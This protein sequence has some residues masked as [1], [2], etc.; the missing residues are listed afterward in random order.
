MDLNSL[1]IGGYQEGDIAEIMT[2]ERDCFSTPWSENIFRSELVSPLSR[3]L[4]GRTDHGQGKCVVGY[5]VY[6]RV[7]DEIHLHNI[8][9]RR[10]LQ[11]QGIASRLLNEVMRRSQLEG[12]RWITLEVR[13]RNLPAQMMY[14]KIGFSL[15][16]VRPGYYTDTHED[17]LIMW[18]DLSLIAQKRHAEPPT[19]KESVEEL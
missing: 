7:A 19:N 4:I 12:A 16:G 1:E 17:A 18:M 3:M 2:I 14:H 10:D 11:R 9:V 8:A 13:Q 6:W 15:K 5:T